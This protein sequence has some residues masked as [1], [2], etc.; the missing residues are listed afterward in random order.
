MILKKINFIFFKPKLQSK[1]YYSLMRTKFLKNVILWKLSK[2]NYGDK[3][4]RFAEIHLPLALLCLV[5]LNNK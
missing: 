2:K 5:K 4:Q 1:A 3:F